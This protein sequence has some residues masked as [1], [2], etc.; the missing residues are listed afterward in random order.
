MVGGGARGHSHQGPSVELSLGPRNVCEVRRNGRGGCSQDAPKTHQLV[1]NRW[2]KQ[3]YEVFVCCIAR[4]AL[5][6]S[7]V[8]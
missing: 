7:A 1:S 6:V 8:L 5:A 3:T 4:A 2:R